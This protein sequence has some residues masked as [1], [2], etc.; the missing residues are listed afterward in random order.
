[1]SIIEKLWTT[2]ENFMIMTEGLGPNDLGAAEIDLLKQMHD[3]PGRS[4]G[5]CNLTDHLSKF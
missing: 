2:E 5:I 4:A 1:M 3:T